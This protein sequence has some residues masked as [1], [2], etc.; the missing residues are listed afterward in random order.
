M[1]M[2]DKSPF[3][4]LMKQFPIVS[5]VVMSSKINIIMNS[6]KCVHKQTNKIQSDNQTCM[7]LQK[8]E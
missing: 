7:E 6:N 2:F 3:H 8:D 4:E 1:T 5:L